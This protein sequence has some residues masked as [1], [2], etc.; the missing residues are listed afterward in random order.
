MVQ[1]ESTEIIKELGDSNKNI[2][3]CNFTLEWNAKLRASDIIDTIS[4]MPS[5]KSFVP[6]KGKEIGRYLSQLQIS[7]QYLKDCFLSLVFILSVILNTYSSV[8]SVWS[9]MWFK[10]HHLLIWTM[11]T[12]IQT[13]L[14][15]D[16]FWLHGFGCFNLSQ[17]IFSLLMWAQLYL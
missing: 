5:F 15:P 4:Y 14:L 1:R 16:I 9:R 10:Y 13:H 6:V 2:W 3:T 11:E 17:S 12:W 7:S 8:K